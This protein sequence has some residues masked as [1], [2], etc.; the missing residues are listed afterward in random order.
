MALLL[1]EALYYGKATKPRGN[2]AKILEEILKGKPAAL[3]KS[4][5]DFR[6]DRVDAVDSSSTSDLRLIGAVNPLHVCER[7]QRAL[8]LE[9]GLHPVLSNSP[10]R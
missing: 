10:L 2:R 7:R 1:G 8:R 6:C 5:D 4:R 3:L 9:N